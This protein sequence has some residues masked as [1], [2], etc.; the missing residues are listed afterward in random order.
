[1]KRI[2]IVVVI[3]TVLDT[4]CLSYMQYKGVFTKPE[5][6]NAN[7]ESNQEDKDD[8]EIEIIE[9]TLD[10]DTIYDKLT[11]KS[12]SVSNKDSDIIVNWLYNKQDKEYYLYLPTSFNRKKLNIRFDIEEQTIISVYDDEENKLGELYNEEVSSLFKYDKVILKLETNVVKETTYKVNIISSNLPTLFIDVDGGNDAF[13]QILKSTSHSVSKTGK[14]TLLDTN[15]DIVSVDMKKFKGRGN[16]TWKRPKKP[17]AI[18]LDKNKSLLGM[19]EENDWILLAN[20]PDGS[21]SRNAIFLYLATELGLDYTPEYRPLDVFINNEYYGSYLLTSKVESDKSRIDNNDD[22]LLEIDNHPHGDELTLATG[23]K[24]TIHNPD[25]DDLSKEE[26]KELRKTL[27]EKL[28]KLESVMNDKNITKEE[29]E[30]YIDLESFAKYYWVQELSLNYDAQRGSN[31][32]YYKDGIVYA[33]PIWDMDNTINRSYIFTTTT[34]YYILESNSMNKRVKNNWYRGL[35]N[36]T[37]F[38]EL[39]D[40]VFINNL[41]LFL[42][43][44]DKLDEYYELI[45]TSTKMNYMKWS[46]SEMMVEDPLTTW[47]SEDKSYQDS[48]NLLKTALMKRINWYK[49]QYI[50]YDKFAYELVDN[51]G[52]IVTGEFTK[53]TTVTLNQSYAGLNMKIYG[54]LAAG[55][56][57]ELKEVELTNGK[58]EIEIVLS[59]KT[60]SSYKKTNKTKYLL[61]FNIK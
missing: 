11:I 53:D 39:I 22:Y 26:Q 15:G 34:G 35:M 18:K 45:D 40:E 44:G 58:N 60:T 61:T 17:F 50:T 16:A 55:T 36:K 42:S 8:D 23:K 19:K 21:L 5:K 32:F 9:H 12:I 2:M 31:Y 51:D 3:L 48:R 30:R 1:M 7:L 59:K 28:N 10:D 43:L 52:K 41:D 4:S 37:Y 46:Y 56:K 13:K 24:I 33:G 27:I 25:L 38:Q 54:V 20:Y 14:F 49:A 57:K 47:R 29:L 6:I